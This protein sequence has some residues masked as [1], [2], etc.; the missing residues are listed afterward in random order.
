MKT[1][2]IFPGQ[3]A[4]VIGMGKE[5]YETSEC[6]KRYIDKA[7]KI[8]DF[9]LID[10]LFNENDRIDNTEY[11]Q[12]ALLA[13]SL[14][15]YFELKERGINPDVTAGLSL[16]EYGSLVVAGVMSFE[17]AIKTV[18]KRGIYMANEVPEGK[19]GMSAVIGL[20]SEKIEKVLED[21]DGVSIANYNCPGQIVISGIKE[22]VEAVAEP[23]K[24]AGA[25]RIIPLNVSGPFHS[26]MLQGA[27]EKLRKVLDEIEINKPV[28]PYVTNVTGEYVYENNKIKDL[29]EVQVYSS[30]KWI[31]S[32]ENML[33]DG[34][35]T[36]V[37]IGP[38]K[39]L[40][41]FVKKIAKGYEV[42]TFNISTP[43]E[44]LEYVKEVENA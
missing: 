44:L 21:I 17:N 38:N 11:T 34:V 14:S 3:G 42:K 20:E 31:Q 22:Q 15:I 10:T 7:N 16:G 26:K 36:F 25:R 32:V 29:L 37:E 30:V 2:F 19:G 1:A 33:K 5:F 23:L 8:L 24:E 9:D 43:D 4:Q 40:T 39:T 12:S 13:V 35:D 27:G 41:S 28:I 6:F 18:R